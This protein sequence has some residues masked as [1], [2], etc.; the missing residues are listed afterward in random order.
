MALLSEIRGRLFYGWVV[1]AAAFVLSAVIFGTRYSFGV[2]FKSLERDFEL[3]R[4]ATSGVFSVYMTVAIAFAVLGGWALDRYG[5]RIVVLLMGVFTGLSLI[6]TSRASLPW[7]LFTSHGLLFAIGTGAA[8]TVLM[9]TT[10]RWFDRKR[11]LALGIVSSGTGLGT[12][13]MAPFATYLITNFGWRMAFIVVG[14]IA[15]LLIASLA[16]LLKKDPGEIG[17]LPDGLKS[18][19]SET[20]TSGGNDAQPISFSL[21]QALGTRSF[22]LLTATWFLW[23][24]CLHFVL[25]HIVPHAIDLGVSAG[26]ASLVLGLI[27]LVSV[28]SR[29]IVG[30]V[31]DRMGRK[32]SAV[33]CALLQA[34]AMLWLIWAQELWMLYVFA[35]IFGVGYGGFDPPTVALV[36]DTFGLRSL[37]MVM[38][39]LV[40]GWGMGAAIGPAAGGLIYDVSQSYFVAFLMG[41]LFMLAAA[42]L[43]SFIRRE[44]LTNEPALNLLQT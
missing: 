28:P 42:L 37:G 3:T 4:A 18:Y 15:G 12:V 35:V 22:W 9:S 31:S 7:H 32:A 24:T 21:R 13:I 39:V 16:S 2:F 11:G 43:V 6:L 33:I 8:Y 23:S 34:G 30:G 44:H 5:P 41:A 36:G 10:S 14:L 17:A 19:T 40:F 1:V 20:E 25:T 26:E 29:L 27:G 38:G